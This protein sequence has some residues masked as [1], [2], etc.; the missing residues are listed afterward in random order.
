MRGVACGG[1]RGD[2]EDVDAS[3]AET[4]ARRLAEG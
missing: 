4:S 1:E 3:G 2:G